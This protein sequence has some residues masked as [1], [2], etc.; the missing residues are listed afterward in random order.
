MDLTRHLAVAETVADEAEAMFVAGLGADPSEFKLPGDFATHAD[1]EIEATVREMLEEASGIHVY[2]EEAGGDYDPQAVWIVDPIDGTSNYAA[3]NPM[4]AILIS[5]IVDGQPRVAVTSIPLL[6]RRL[7]MVDGGPVYVNGR[8]IEPIADRCELVS[9]V[10]FSS[11][12]SPK[13]SGHSSGYRQEMLSRLASGP[14]RPRITGSV[15]VDLAL[16]AQGIFDASVSF[17]PYVWDNA[18]GVALVRAAGGVVTDI[19]GDAWH[20][21]ATGV[22]AG[23]PSAHAEIMG[24]MAEIDR[25]SS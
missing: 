21:Q 23:T 25:S 3:G 9:Q 4:C 5:L 17:S 7:T 20:P 24:T 10:G 19:N 16:T 13:T 8:P 1:L 12:S 18:A 15:G 14:L 2:G 22:V 6:G 11:V